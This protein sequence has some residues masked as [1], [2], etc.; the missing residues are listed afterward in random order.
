MR[1]SSTKYIMTDIIMAVM[2]DVL[3]V[4]IKNKD[5]KSKGWRYHNKFCPSFI[6][7]S[8]IRIIDLQSFPYGICNQPKFSLDLIISPM[9]A[10][11]HI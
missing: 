6:G 8:F 2:Y 10:K 3:E 9:C 1:V 7:M 11:K 5:T 4:G